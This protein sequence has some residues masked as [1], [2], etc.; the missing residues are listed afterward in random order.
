MP[1]D[2]ASPVGPL[3]HIQAFGTQ[4][5]YY[6]IRFDKDGA[7]LSAQS[8]DHLIAAI[9]NQGYT[10]V[11]LYSH[12]WNNDFPTATAL[13]D[14]FLTGLSEM[15]AVHPL[16]PASFRPVFVGIS[17]PSTALVFGAEG[18]PDIAAVGE[19][20][21]A[22]LLDALPEPR[23]TEAAAM[24]AEQHVS[25]EDAMRLAGWLADAQ[26]G[27]SD[28]EVAAGTPDA[29]D[30]VAGWKVNAEAGPNKDGFSD[31]G[32]AP[33]QDARPAGLQAAGLEMLDPR[34]IVRLATVLIMKDRAGI[35]GANGVAELIR[36]LLNGT[37]AHIHL[38]GHS[39]GAK[40]VMTALGTLSA[41]PPRR[42]VDSALLLQ[43]AVSRLCFAAD[44]GDGTPGGFVRALPL[45][46]KPVLATY[47]SND[48]P[49]TQI[50]HLVARRSL[51]A[52]ELQMAGEPSRFAALGGFGAARYAAGTADDIA[53]LSAGTWPAPFGPAIRVVSLN[54]SN[55][56]GGHGDVNRAETFWAALNLLK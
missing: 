31:F 7:C 41:G 29:D 8:V 5:P 6:V 34:W 15:A 38:F 13:Y 22:I 17:W 53:L 32:T 43:P 27:A 3:K 1:A 25:M 56:I 50:F 11:L 19:E 18:G 51:D 48:F 35:V 37:D 42:P 9:R 40:V 4:L 36:Q 52:G 39:Y 54:G 49:L 2:D 14:R 16:L 12:G 55:V 10:H 47:S 33:D 44:L 26:A 23:R 24:L 30:I 45:V 28:G 20:E 21:E 46:I